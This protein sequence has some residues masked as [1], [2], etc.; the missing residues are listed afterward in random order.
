M[1][2]CPDTGIHGI[3]QFLELLYVNVLCYARGLQAIK[4]MLEISLQ[5]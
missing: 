4:K 5:S 1:V 2:N 3:M